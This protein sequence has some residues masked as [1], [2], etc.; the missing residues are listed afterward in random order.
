[1]Q[2]TFKGEPKQLEGTQPIVGEKA[3]AFSA[4]NIQGKEVSLDTLKGEVAILSVFPDITT[5]VCDQQ[6]RRFHEVASN[7]QGVKLVSISKNS[8]EELDQWC[9]ANGIDMEMLHDDE[10]VFGKAYGVYMPEMDKLAR[11]VFVVDEE[12]RLAYKEI[13]SEGSNEPN[14]E[15]AVETAKDLV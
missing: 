2:I 1:M 5:R 11:S 12:G 9:A 7:L 15:A 6:T 14:Y 3:P 4:Q 10:A 13:L 8:K